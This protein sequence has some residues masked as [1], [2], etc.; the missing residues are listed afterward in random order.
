[1]T[2]TRNP[3]EEYGAEAR[4]D[5][6]DWVGHMEAVADHIF[7]ARNE[8]MSRP[9]EDIRYGN[10]G[11]VSVNLATGQWYDFENGRGG[12][13]K[14]LIKVYKGIE[15]RDEAIA[16]AKECLN[17]E[18]PGR[19]GGDAV[20]H[21]AGPNRNAGKTTSKNEQRKREATYAYHD[22]NG[23]IAFEVVRFIHKQADGSDAI[24]ADGKRI[25]SF[26]QRRHS[27]EQD[28]SWLS[29]TSAGEFMRSGSGRDWVSFSESKFQQYP[30]RARQRKVFDTPAPVVPYRLPELLQAVANNQ[31][32][33]IAEGE[34]KV[35]RIH[36][37]G[38]A[39]TCNA[40]G[41]KKWSAEHTAFLK[42][43]DVV[44]LPDNDPIGHE[45]M[46]AIAKSLSAVAKRVRALELPNLPEKGD[47]I[48]WR[49]SAEEFAQLIAGAPDYKID[50][51]DRPQPLM[52]PLPKPEPF[53]IDALGPLAAAARG[54]ADIVQ[55]P[56]E[57]CA[58]AVLGSASLAIS[59]HID[60]E[61]PTGEVK[62]TSLFLCPIA[63]SGE[64]KTS[65]D[66]HAFAAQQRWEQQL[67]VN[68]TAELERYR[69]RHE[70]WDAK[71]KAIAK[72]YKDPGA[73]GS[74]AHQQELERLGPEPE[75]PLEALLMSADFT[76][77]GMVRCLNIG[78]PLFGI[79]G[80]EGGQF[81]GG[82]GMTDEAKQRTL[83]NVNE[84]WDGRPIKR[85]RADEAIV[86]PGRR[87]SM[88]L[89]MQ[90]VVAQ[91]LLTDE[92]ATKLGFLGRI[93][94][95]WPESLIGTRLHKEPPPQ[96]KE[97]VAD[98]TTKLLAIL[99]TPLPLVEDTRNELNP[100]PLPFSTEATELFWEFADATEQNM[101]K[102]GRYEIIRPFAAKLPEHAA[103]LAAVIAGYRDIHVRELGREDFVRGIHIASY[104]ASEAKRISE[105]SLADLGLMTAQK[106]LTWLSTEWKEKATIQARDIYT[107]GPNAIRTRDAAVAAAEIL[108]AHGWIKEMKTKRADQKEWQILWSEEQ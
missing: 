91:K 99:E 64:R 56:I 83:A 90:P 39:A 30:T 55:A 36:E 103:R 31:A 86:L 4:G 46:E 42:D 97:N 63:E 94:M 22:A 79:I 35:D 51:R 50:G 24:G 28:G 6:F 44:L 10:K 68:R 8:A 49:G 53:P 59:A 32:I 43:A 21:Q 89:G 84:V 104:F 105:S 12:G 14:E 23:R 61:L 88:H 33:C 2:E 27:G 108:V 62:P 11:S 93:L 87:V 85:V 80:S 37:L 100:R 15:D 66:G 77:E 60:V 102:D 5:H 25:K 67:R 17:G 81:V 76:F 19:H 71:S 106:L 82:H 40:G 98:F 78:Q 34:K 52:R 38:F 9:P 95:C 41:A 58:G 74:Q 70:A 20:N 101:A 45:H 47:I 73:A 1:M 29:G 75:K 92:L 72:Q 26:A 54:I 48:D 107:F 57:M 13:V 3:F 7:E 16:F 18:Q 65:I 69:V 96:A